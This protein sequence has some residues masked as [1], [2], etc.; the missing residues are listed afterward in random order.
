MMDK[1]YYHFAL[2]GKNEELLEALENGIDVNEKDHNGDTLM[3]FGIDYN[4]INF[5]F[6]L[7]LLL[8]FL[9]KK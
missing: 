1:K 4:S 8:L 7:E 9:K 3:H 6:I 2:Q 5:Y